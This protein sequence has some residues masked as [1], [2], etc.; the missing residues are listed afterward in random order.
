VFYYPDLMV[1]CEPFD[2]A[3]HYVEAPRYIVEVTS[4]TT[5]RT[6]RVEKAASY[7]MVPSVE[8]YLIV[9][10][11][12]MRIVVL[13]RVDDAWEAQILT[14][15]DDVLRLDGIGFTAPLAAVYANTDPA[16]G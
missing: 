10:Q 3:A 5:Q 7:L 12:V 16:Q 15:P 6:D 1:H 14:R 4:P 9:E 2:P 13:R 8:A 11:D